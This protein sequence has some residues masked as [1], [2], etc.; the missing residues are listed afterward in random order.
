M[1]IAR[2]QAS[3]RLMARGLE[4]LAAALG[5][6]EAGEDVR[7]AR[8]IEE[9]GRRGLTQKEASALFQRHGFAPQTTGGWARGDWVEIGDDGLRYLTAKSHTWLEERS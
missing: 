9:W 3:L 2:V 8:V 4:E 1:D 6:E 5:D 7:T